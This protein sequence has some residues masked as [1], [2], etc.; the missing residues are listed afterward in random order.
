ME[1]E[2]HLVL[3]TR[4]AECTEDSVGTVERHLVP[5]DAGNPSRKIHFAQHQPSIAR[6]R[7]TD[8]HGRVCLVDARDPG[9]GEATEGSLAGQFL[10]PGTARREQ[11]GFLEIGTAELRRGGVHA[12]SI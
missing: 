2:Y 4:H 8:A 3:T 11:H 12:V 6:S 9:P 5:I 1:F 7:R 10:V